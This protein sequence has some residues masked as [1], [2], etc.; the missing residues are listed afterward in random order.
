MHEEGDGFRMARAVQPGKRKRRIVGGVDTHGDTHHAAVV[1]MNGSRVADQEFPATAAGYAQLLQWLQ[2]FGRLHKVGVEGTGCYGKQLTSTL[3][4]HG[5]SVIEVNRPDR[6]QR[7]Q[8]GKSDPL[9]AYAA[10]EAVLAGR[11]RA[12]PKLGTGIVEAIRALHLTRGGAVKARSAAMNELRAL[13]V[14]APAGLRDQLRGLG[15]AALINAC[16][17]LR[18]GT[19][20]LAD[21]ALAVKAALRSLARR[22]HHL[23]TEITDLDTALHTLIERACPPLLAVHGVGDETA[24]QLLITAGDNPD[25]IG[26]EAA[27]AALCGVAPVPASSGKTRRHRLSTGGDRQANRALYMIACTRLATCPAT[28]AYRDKRTQQ[29]LSTKDTI[30]CLKR[31][32]ARTIYKIITS[33]GPD[34]QPTTSTT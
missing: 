20:D 19:G 9:D 24:A 15:P 4:A 10:A 1:L 14:T 28:R 32:L 33:S 5:V 31:Y 21:P 11:A 30:R 26:S 18:P 25:R 27:F 23:T 3:H 34:A 22:Y 2:G 7:R 13:L 29:G 8:A 12:V 6:A 17:R 16:A